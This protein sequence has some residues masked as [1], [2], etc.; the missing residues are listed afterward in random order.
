MNYVTHK[1]IFLYHFFVQSRFVFLINYDNSEKQNQNFINLCRERFKVLEEI[2]HARQEGKVEEIQ[3]GV[4]T[5]KH[6]SI[7]FF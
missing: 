3:I 4:S 7:F 6:F 1:I 2:T 5:R